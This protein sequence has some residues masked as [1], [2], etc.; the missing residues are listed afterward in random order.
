[1]VISPLKSPAV[2]EGHTGKPDMSNTAESLVTVSRVNID[3]L[4]AESRDSMNDS[5]VSKNQP[6]HLDASNEQ[7][8]KC[9][10]SQVKEESLQGNTKSSAQPESLIPPRSSVN[11]QGKE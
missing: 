6:R 4:P 8:G 5:I 11:G 9:N 1:M 7:K 3:I 10:I 2:L